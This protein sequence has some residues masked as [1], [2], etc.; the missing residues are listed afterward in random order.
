MIRS[1][2]HSLRPWFR[3][4][5]NRLRFPRTVI[6]RDTFIERGSRIDRKAVIGSRCAIFSSEVTGASALG[7]QV[8]IARGCRVGDSRLSTGCRLAAHSQ[9]YQSHL[10]AHV[11]VQE[12]CQLTQ[13]RVGRCSYIA[14]EAYLNDVT[15][16]S[17]CSIGPRTLIGFGEHPHD[18]VSTSPAFY[19]TRAQC[20][21]TFA[22]EDSFVERRPIR[23]GHDVWIGAQVFIR[24]GV[25]IGN[26]AIVAAGAVVTADVPP[27]AIVAGVPARFLRS[28]FS[29][30]TTAELQALGWW[31]WQEEKLHAGQP[32]M[33]A[34]DPGA[35]LDWARRN[36]PFEPKH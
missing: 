22:S 28:R 33:A 27:Y 23:L 2:R 15:A 10:D 14:R 13:V 31:D 12:Q 7:S 32:F 29:D 6:G 4:F 8:Q 17:F 24:D 16:G 5:E 25:S 30:E 1:F 11:A 34:R 9:V 19:S 18:F 20:G 36:T 35:F 26:G 21:I 3:Q